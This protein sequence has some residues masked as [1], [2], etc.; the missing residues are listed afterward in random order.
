M[1]ENKHGT[2]NQRETPDQS[3]DAT[4]TA[5]K[6]TLLRILAGKRLVKTKKCTILG[7]DVFMKPPGVSIC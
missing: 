6:S 4:S 7:Q 2:R 5:G 3:A 1:R